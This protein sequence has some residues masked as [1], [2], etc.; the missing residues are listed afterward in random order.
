MAITYPR[1]L[2][3]YH[4]SEC[5]HDLIDNVSIA[6]SGNGLVLNRSQFVDPI[7]QTTIVT[8]LLDIVKQ[9][10]WSAWKK[11]LGGGLRT[12]VAY[13][14]RRQTPLAYP[15]AKAPTDIKAGWNGT[16]T[17]TSVG[18]SGALGLSGL[19]E[20]YKVTVGDRIGLEQSNHYGYYEIIESVTANGAGVATVTVTPFLHSS[21]F[22]TAAVARIW[23]PKCEFVIGQA[24]Y[25]E[26]GTKEPS[27]ISFT[28]T[29]KL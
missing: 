14:V 11:S 3:D 17:V 24:N 7:W 26:S 22:T 2:P 6:P 15:N 23:R 19:P 21:L 20:N 10:E 28:G 13:D 1:D 27:P 8:G 16:A 12:F 5:W 9:A 25:S 18:L 29:Q 4:L